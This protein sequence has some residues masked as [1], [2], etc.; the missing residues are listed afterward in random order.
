MIRIQNH[1][2]L[3]RL[4]RIRRCAKSRTYCC[5]WRELGEGGKQ[6]P[7]ELRTEI[8]ITEFRSIK[9]SENCH[10]RSARGCVLNQTHRLR[11]C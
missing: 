9:A 6:K 10:H 5:Q 8:H 1:E 4:T 7:N 2:H 11:V 3:R